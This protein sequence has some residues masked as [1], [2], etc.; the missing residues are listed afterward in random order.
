MKEY[1]AETGGR[2]TYSDDILNLQ[3]LAL[4]LTSIFSECPAFIISGCQTEGNGIAPGY[5]WLGGKIRYF[6]G[7][8]ST[9]FPYFVYEANANE[10]VVYANEVNKRG[11]CCY[12][13]S[14]GT[15]VPQITDPV[16]GR[17]PEY[18]EI[19]NDYAPRITDKFFGRYALLLDGPASRQKVKKD[20]TF[21]GEV[22]VEKSLKSTKEVITQGTNGRSFRN[23]VK[24]SGEGS[25]GAYLNDLLTSEITLNTDGSFSFL[26]G[27]TELARLDENGFSCDAVSL[28]QGKI[29]S[30]YLYQNHLINISD[31]TDEGSVNINYCGYNQTTNR[32]RSFRVYDGKRCS[33]PLFQVEGKT[34][35]T[36]VN[37]VFRVNGNG[38]CYILRNA[39]FAKGDPELTG[40]LEWQDRDCTA[41]ASIGYVST[42]TNDFTV[43]NLFGNLVFVSKNS[44]DLSG[45]VRI[46]GVDIYSIFVTE[47]SFTEALAKKVSAVSGKQ[48][49]T[50]DFTS[51]YKK[52]LDAI[53]GGSI[54]AGGNGY[55]TASDV[56]E[57]LKYKLNVSSNLSDLF[58][59]GVARTNLSVYS[60][61]ETDGKYLT[62]SGKLKELVSL[63]ADEINGMN[64]EEAAALKAEKQAEI[65]AV[66]DAEKRGTGDLKLAKSSNLSD[67]ADRAQ[68]RKNISVYSVTEIDKMLEGKLS[69]DG[70]YTGIVFTEAMKQK[71]EGIK[72]GNFAYIDSNGISQVQ[73][74]GYALISNL[75]KELKQYAPRLL[76]GYNS[77]EKDSI[78]ANIG[79]Y[80]KTVA[81]GKFASVEQ[82]FQ[83]YI[84]YLVKSGKTTAQ[85]QQTLRDKF[86]V[87][88]KKEITDTYLRKDGK[89]SD[90]SLPN[91]DAKKLAC[92]NLGA[93]YADEYQTKLADTGWLQMNNSGSGTDTRQLFIRQIGNIVSIQGIINTANR[94]GSNMGGVVAVIPNQIQPPKYGL[95]CSLCDYNDDHKY[96]RGSSFIIRANSRNIQLYESGWYNAATEINFT[97]FV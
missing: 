29:G 85:A 15:S 56:A 41:I 12:L 24:E 81:D 40:V 75:V 54:E 21:T 94:D 18:L 78:A 39:S 13:C 89:L 46:K 10:S 37:G 71:L 59:K 96:N 55:V 70:A 1:I 22:I 65:R 47:K 35:T 16:T 45:T 42:L 63:S 76:D 5:V 66:L 20:L 62:I 73:V 72:T 74:E 60:K 44:I 4:S 3:E 14:G 31:D 57:S 32:F 48:L 91:A 88:S 30:V 34:R 43:S 68:A 36:A 11:R 51:D 26:K 53:S 69:S 79:V 23:R 77:S 64:P 6:E 87:F 25:L 28:K 2:Y 50:E 92:R 93:A 67:L 84:T 97:Y 61:S 9:I 58:D 90:L 80:T 83:D 95:R 38:S 17:L 27:T 33:V 7:V 86:D 49:S 52:K 8:Q 19:G 82:L